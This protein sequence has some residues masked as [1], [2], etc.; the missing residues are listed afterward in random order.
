VRRFVPEA[1]ILL[2]PVLLLWRLIL[3][4][5]VVYWGVPMTQFYPWHTLVNRALASG[6]L[7]LWTDLLGAGAPLLANHQTAIF[8]P[9]NLIFRLFP[10]EHAI[11]YSLL[12]HLIGA[13]MAACF[14]A[15]TL[16]LNRLGQ[17][18]LALSYALGGYIVGR[19]QFATM[20][21]AYAWLPLLLALS[22]RLVSRRRPRDLAL[23]GL[24]QSLQFLAGH[25]QLW[26][27][28]L[29]LVWMYAI[30]RLAQSAVRDRTMRPMLTGTLM[31]GGA[32]ALAVGTAAVQVIPTAELA[33]QS[34][35][36]SGAAWDFAMTYSYWP[37]RLL[38][39]A[40]PDIF[41]S[42]ALGNFS[43]YANYWEDNAYLGILPLLFALLAAA[44]WIKRRLRHAPSDKDSLSEAVTPFWALM[45]PLAILL[46]LGKNTPIFPWFFQHVPGF[47]YFQ[48]P[49]R[50]MLWFALAASTLAG[51][52]THQFH[53][54]YR[55]Q[56]TLRLIAASTGAML[57]VSLAAAQ[58][59]IPEVHVPAFTRLA[60]TVAVS[61][62]ILLLGGQETEG[63][64][65]RVVKS[66]LS[67]PVWAGLVVV[68][69][70][71]DLLLH[72][73]PLTPTT[74]PEVYEQR[75][76]AADQSSRLFVDPQYEY[77]VTF[78][79]YFRFDTFGPTAPA[80]WGELRQLG[81]PNLNAVDQVSSLNNNDPLVV[82]R[83][84]GFMEALQAAEGRKKE[85]LLRTAGVGMV[86]TDSPTPK[87][88]PVPET[89]DLYILHNPAA[90]AWLA[91]T[92]TAAADAE[93]AM[94]VMLA[95][96][97]DP[98]AQVVIETE[99][100]PI[101]THIPE[102]AKSST[103]QQQDSIEPL[104]TGWNRRTIRVTASRPAYLVLAY[105]Y[106]PG[107]Q[108]VT[109]GHPAPLWRANYAF[110]ALAVEPGR[111]EI[112][113]TYRPWWLIVG[114]IISGFSLLGSILLLL[115]L[116][117]AKLKKDRLTL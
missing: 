6:N 108:A 105:T 81:L 56:Y 71:V 31:L 101:S 22:E 93:A 24:A 50:L 53:L 62:G 59:S 35:R 72:G 73:M 70:G 45:I 60:L 92:V 9:L 27:Y 14:W 80:F 116:V 41:G 38:T 46:A 43:G 106:Y 78:D 61:A 98:E 94:A 54:T 77:D 48:A 113:M 42:P 96:D 88:V 104:H 79:T 29:L 26:F 40:A 74:S 55:R 44:H 28:S 33:Q 37:W 117:N 84:R 13:G 2:A 86:L 112:V 36:S 90:T 52:G 103:L 23:L 4:G 82:G 34:Q 68:C 63:A 109:D 17:T 114:P 12:L 100:I 67:Y 8:Y 10:V 47:G 99:T 57:L 97:F 58:L 32:L 65:P 102:T 1:V 85:A 66:P 49:A 115:P 69:I 30:F 91:P 15:R 5:Q 7:P 11:G 76:A 20:V 16:G 18:T 75:A 89:K 110:T 3:L 107:W 21:A 25:A 83:W 87:M 39:L 51:I 19:T 111:H 95:E 64:D